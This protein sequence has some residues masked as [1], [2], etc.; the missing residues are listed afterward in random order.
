MRKLSRILSSVLLGS[1]LLGTAAC[2]GGG[3]ENA[4]T[5]A[6]NAE[7]TEATAETTAARP[8]LKLPKKDYNG[9]EFVIYIRPATNIVNYPA[10]QY[11]EELTG[12]VLSDAIYKRNLAVSEQF[13]IKF[14][15]DE[16]ETSGGTGAA[17]VIQAGDDAY[18]MIVC[19][20]RATF[21]YATK[22]LTLE[23]NKQLPYVDLDAEWWNQNARENFTICN[24]LY[25]MTGG[26]S[27][28]GYASTKVTYFNK[29]LCKDLGMEY[30]YQAVLNDTW[31]FDKF[32][33]MVKS[34]YKDLDGDTKVD[35]MKDQFGFG[36][37]W[38]GTPINILYTAGESLC[39]ADEK[40][41]H[42]SINKEG[43]I[44]ALEKLTALSKFDGCYLQLKDGYDDI[45]K[46][47][48]EGRML[49]METQ[50]ASTDTLRAMDDDFGIIPCAKI[51]DTIDGYYTGVDAGGNGIC[52]P[53]TAS[54][55]ERTSVILEA[56]C[57]NGYYDVI[58]VYY[59]VVLTSKYAR[60]AESVE[61][62]DIIFAGRIYDIGYYMAHNFN[63]FGHDL[64]SKNVE[65]ASYYASGE[66]AA[67]TKL[68]EI[69]EFYL[70]ND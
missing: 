68:A 49:F 38:W 5:T 11:S 44:N 18:D 51:D 23:W 41:M 9:Y 45:T 40:G 33:E 15:A 29:N 43:V 12:D 8:E 22:G 55:A 25:S 39:T 10:D 30:P 60:D 4:E 13:N 35:I 64:F 3:N 1:M 62:L 24:K 61:M 42:L 27:Y 6:A 46:A 32:G 16:N 26:I 48:M 53:V 70:K 47:F 19:H 63:S 58:P 67:N 28:N 14:V 56:L 59:D 31:T 65:F 69:N 36:S 34:A 50:L 57:Y 37:N 17:T 52:I 66:S 21:A 7:V 2:G 54:D 20:A